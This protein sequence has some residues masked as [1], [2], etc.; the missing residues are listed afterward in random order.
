MA[1][2]NQGLLVY[3]NGVRK[4]TNSNTT[5]ALFQALG[6][7][8][9]GSDHGVTITE[10][11]GGFDFNA[12]VLGNIG[13]ASATGQ[14]VEFDQYTTALAGK[15]ALAG[16][17]MTGDIAMGGHKVTGL[18]SPTAGSADAAT[19]L[20]VDAAV[21]ATGTAA[22]WQNS[23]ITATILDPSTIAGT[24]IAGDRYLISGTGAGGWTGKDDQIAQYVSG[25]KSLVGS[26]TY[27]VATAGTF[28]DALDANTVLYYYGGA[29][30]VTKQF[31]A[32]TASGFLAKTGV[33]ITFKN[34]ANGKI[35]VGDSG[36]LAQ[37]VTATGDVT[38]SNTGVTAIAND[39]VTTVKILDAN[40]TAAKLAT[41]SV[42]SG[43]ILADAVTTIK[44][45]DANVTAAKLA[46]DS[47][48]TAKILDA[49]VTAAKLASDSVTTIKILDA[50]V[51]TAKI[52]D[53]A[54]TKAKLDASFDGSA[55]A[56]SGETLNVQVGSEKGVQI[57]SDALE[58]DYSRTMNNGSASVA[59]AAQDLV[60]VD[61][62]GKVQLAQANVTDLD[63]FEIGISEGSILAG[64]S[65]TG[66]IVLR[67]GA[68]YGGFS[69]LTPGAKVYVSRT[70][71]GALTQSLS[72]FVS[73][74]HVYSVG[75]AVSATEISYSPEHEYQLA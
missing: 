52:A 50:N 68:I 16:G 19:A 74:E 60:Y 41:D 43:K 64:T 15:L 48:I 23:V 61:A 29:S 71:A 21:A 18:G 51:T 33:D 24:P 7:T 10:S 34:L 28:T 26:W 73:G 20:Y 22:Q 63:T 36:G 42:T 4:V 17:T 13:T 8:S 75:R 35:L 54:V 9:D 49:N 72:G 45:L 25:S 57:V 11:G 31:E 65:N 14:A 67:R 3:V 59:I 2:V 56:F 62:T 39:A 12:K 37:A 55:L 5:Q 32:T 58:G 53:N 6:F 47:V 40:V 69:S 1:A 70:T 66:R 30:W 38:V 46:P 27:Y 44:I